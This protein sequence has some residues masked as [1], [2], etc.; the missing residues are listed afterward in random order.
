MQG[1]KGRKKK[2]KEDTVLKLGGMRE[3]RLSK[4]LVEHP[5]VSWK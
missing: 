4:V 5:A 2:E 3:E 1:E